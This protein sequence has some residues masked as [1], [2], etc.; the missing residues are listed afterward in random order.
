MPHRRRMRMD[1]AKKLNDYLAHQ[2]GYTAMTWGDVT[3]T[4]VTENGRKKIKRQIKQLER[5]L[6]V[7]RDVRGRSSVEVFVYALG[8]ILKFQEAMLA[9]QVELLDVITELCEANDKRDQ[10]NN[11]NYFV[12]ITMIQKGDG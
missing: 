12:D 10:A 2:E 4:G 7:L 5:N 8:H 6:I 11:I 3:R 9:E 1:E